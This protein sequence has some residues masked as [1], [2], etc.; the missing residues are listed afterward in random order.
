MQ[1]GETGMIGKCSKCSAQMKLSKCP[2]NCAVH[3]VFEDGSSCRHAVTNFNKE[4]E[5]ICENLIDDII[6]E[7]FLSASHMKLTV[8]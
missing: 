3:F 4:I 6:T 5:C 1:N 7:K 8:N 2:Q